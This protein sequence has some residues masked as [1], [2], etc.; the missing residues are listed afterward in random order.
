[1]L[2]GEPLVRADF[3]MRVEVDRQ[4][5][6]VTPVPHRDGE[7]PD[8]TGGEV[9]RGGGQSGEFQRVVEGHDVDDRGVPRAQV[10]RQTEVPLQIFGPVPLVPAQFDHPLGDLPEEF[11]ERQI[12]PQGQS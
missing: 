1:M 3:R 5:G 10:A 9:V 11:P 4:S 12:R 8:Q 7:V 6:A 2:G